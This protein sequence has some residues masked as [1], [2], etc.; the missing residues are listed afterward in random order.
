MRKED[1]GLRARSCVQRIRNWGVDAV[2]CWHG[3][4]RLLLVLLC[5]CFVL[6]FLPS[7]SSGSSSPG[8]A[9]QEDGG[10]VVVT[11]SSPTPLIQ[12]N[13]M[14]KAGSV[15]DPSGRSGLAF[16]TAHTLLEGGYGDP[17]SPVTKE[18]LALMTRAWGDRAR[19]S[20]QVSKEVTTFQVTI[21]E[22]LLDQH[23]DTILQPLFTR[24]LFDEEELNRLRKETLERVS[25]SLRYEDIES[26]GLELIDSYLFEDTPYAHPTLGSIQGLGNISRADLLSY[27]VTYY[28]PGNLIV[29]LSKDAPRIKSRISQAL[30]GLGQ[31]FQASQLSRPA[32]R[33][34][35]EFKGRHLLI[36]AQPNASSTGIHAG[37][38]LPITRSDADFWPLHIANVFFGT[39]RDSFSHLFREIRQKRGYNYGDYSYIEHFAGKPFRLFPSFNTPRQ[40]QYFSIWI[41]PVAH[42]YVHHLT[43]AVTWELENFVRLGMTDEQVR[44]AKNKAR[45]LYLNLAETVSR[46][47]SARVDDAYYGM[48][49]DG[50][51]QGYLERIDAVSTEQVNTAIRKH[52]QSR[53]M[54]YVVVTDDDVADQ[55]AETMATDHPA[56]GKTLQEYGIDTVQEGD[57]SSYSIPADKLEII[58]QDAVW[59]AYPLDIPSANIRVLPVEQVFER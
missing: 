26:L 50:Y 36:V 9:L 15:D 30:S 32:R 49:Q 51:L 42:Q 37:F 31:G 48:L 2:D 21:P 14:I 41:R 20:V 24:P 56:G 11:L 45:I 10:P 25:G 7:K 34:P 52:L 5:L 3:R 4:R 22:D 28:R 58:K 8:S 33:P 17:D 43:K 23:L 46:L 12:V 53:N 29:G 1:M 38:P 39:H 35:K 6:F 57:T 55:L 16:L 13:V 18:R 40:Q 47:L 59:S 54:K 27:F 44:L 19:P